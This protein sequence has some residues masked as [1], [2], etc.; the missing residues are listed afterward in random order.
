MFVVA[1]IVALIFDT[2]HEPSRSTILVI[3]S[4]YVAYWVFRSVIFFNIIAPDT[5][6]HRM[7]NLGRQ[8]RRHHAAGLAQFH[9]RRNPRF[10]CMCVDGNAWPEPKCPQIVP[11]DCD[12]HG[13]VDLRLAEYQAQKSVCRCHSGP[14]RSIAQ[15][16]SEAHVCRQL[17]YHGDHLSFRLPG[18][19]VSYRL[20]MDKD[21]ANMLVSAP[22]MAAIAALPVYGII[23]III[24]KFYVAPAEAV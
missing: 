19:S 4:A 6:K 2:G 20:I 18:L 8:D 15:T 9:D 10:R 21:S 13:S 23:L 1:I 17:A 14:G 12:G 22:I 24:D 3:V 5:P 11:C 16:G 7:I